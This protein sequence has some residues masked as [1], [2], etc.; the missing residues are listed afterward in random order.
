VD[1]RKKRDQLLKMEGMAKGL[2]LKELIGFD[3][4]YN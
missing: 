4:M 3:S 2:K 1:K